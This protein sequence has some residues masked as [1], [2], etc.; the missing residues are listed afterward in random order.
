[1]NIAQ[2]PFWSLAIYFS[3]RCIKKEKL[4]DYVFLGLFAGL[5]ILSKYLFIY[6]ALGISLLFVY[7]IKKRK[8]IFLKNYLAAILTTCLVLLPHI[9]WLINN[10]F[11]SIEY[12][13]SRT[14]GVGNFL[15]TSLYL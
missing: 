8:K 4:L 1:M 13:F 3:W 5:G 15:N 9:I 7:L 2:L 10:Q 12:G 14:G 6:L 11:P